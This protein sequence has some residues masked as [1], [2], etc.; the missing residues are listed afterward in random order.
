[1][2]TIHQLNLLGALAL[3]AGLPPASVAQSPPSPLP[4]IEQV[5]RAGL[6]IGQ[7]DTFGRSREG[8]WMPVYVKIHSGTKPTRAGEF[9]L[10]VEA[11]D[12][13]ETPYRNAL[14]LP[15]LAA[16]ED[17]FTITYLRAT[18]AEF[19]VWLEGPDGVVPKS[20][21]TQRA[22]GE[23]LR[24]DAVLCLA[25]GG[26]PPQGLRRSL[27]PPK[28]RA[29]GGPQGPPRVAVPPIAGDKPGQNQPGGDQPAQPED[30]VEI[31]LANSYAYI[32][33]VED[34]PEHWFGYDAADVVFLLTDDA[35]LLEKLANAP[36]RRKALV[37]WVRRGGKLVISVGSK[38]DLVADLLTKMPL[39]EGDKGTLIDCDIGHSAR[40]KVLRA[41]SLNTWVGVSAESLLRN[42]EVA[43]LTPGPGTRVLLTEPAEDPVAKPDAFYA[44]C[45][46]AG[47]AAALGYQDE[48]RPLIVDAPCGLGRV[49][50]VAFDLDNRP[51]T[52]WPGQEQTWHALREEMVPGLKPS[53]S[54]Q[55]SSSQDE[56]LRHM[57]SGVETFGEVPTV[58]FGWVALFI[59]V[60]IVIVGPLDYLVLAKVFK[61]LELTWVTFPAVVLTL[62][63]GAYFGAYA[64][65]GD[66]RRFN[67]TDVVEIDLQ[68]GQAYGT[69]WFA[70][71]SPRIE[72]YTVGVEP[73]F[74]GKALTPDNS[75]DGHSAVVTVLE[76]PQEINTLR[77]GSRSLFNRPYEYAPAVSGLERVPIPV[78]SIR[79]F[80]A[81][82][83]TPLGNDKPIQLT[84]NK[85]QD[86]PSLTLLRNGLSGTIKNNLPVTLKDV[87][88]FYHGKYY[89]KPMRFDLAPGASFP[90]SDFIRTD[91]GSPQI[92]TWL[93]TNDPLWG[94]SVITQV[95]ERYNWQMQQVTML[96]HMLAKQLMFF[97]RRKG[98]SANRDNSGLRR[99]DQDWRLQE[100]TD[101]GAPGRPQRYVDEVIL[102]ARTEYVDQGDANDVNKK[103]LVRL[104]IGDLPRGNAAPPVLVG[105]TTE[106]TFVRVYIPVRLPGE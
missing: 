39:P 6:P 42:V 96:P 87:T 98:V 11:P 29:Q 101:T 104:W 1:M 82:W 68:S 5:I 71:F 21:S 78:W 89:R 79:S 25:I 67:K 33:R 70:I 19:Q 103:S 92:G 85:G 102:V 41:S 36:T 62:S 34:M 90:V 13:E 2:R 59:V 105:Q 49:L 53:G 14:P 28:D 23:A 100:V 35:K 69:S 57:R 99:L 12:D 97:P 94:G 26:F 17:H 84:D 47:H 74:P 16:N 54:S 45:G 32:D 20:Q 7:G 3:M 37:E 43:R 52:S 63:I 44:A 95:R 88:L 46:I 58:S 50:L 80:T 83:R 30:E 8:T 93:D 27:L 48:P 75:L 91:E 72:N 64:L 10:V 56:L 31:G 24:G 76:A 38:A 40:Y 60:Y 22:S 66:K 106:N 77:G 73:V 4:K 55:S 86:A 51:F 9:R 15:A 81:S 65:K 61:R 18:N